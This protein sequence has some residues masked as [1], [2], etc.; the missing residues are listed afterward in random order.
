MAAER[1]REL[2]RRVPAKPGVY[3]FKDKAGCVIY[4]GKAA[5]LKD[6]IR[7]YFA[8][9]A[10][11]AEK[12]RRM[13][14]RAQDF[15]YV[16]T[17]SEQEA[18]ILENNLI[19]KHFP[20]YNVRLRDDKS[21]PY[22]KISVNEDFPRIYVTRRLESD[23][24]R[25][26]G[27]YASAYSV[28]LTL[29]MLRNVFHFRSCRKPIDGKERR[30]CL[31]YHIRR[32]RA[33]CV[34]SITREDYRHTIDQVMLFLE[35]RQEQIVRDL[36]TRMEDAAG[37]LQFEKAALLRDQ[38]LAVESVMQQQKVVSPIPEDEDVVGLA[39]SGDEGCVQLFFVRAGKLT[40]QDHFVMEGAQ[41]EEPRAILTS[42]V[43]QF[44]G[45]ASYV[46]PRILLPEKLEDM[47]VVQAW[48]SSRRGA[49]VELRAPQ[50]GEKKKLVA[51]AAQNAAEMLEQLRA[52][53][54]ADAGK[55]QVAQEELQREL[56]LPR[57]PR[58]IECYDI[59]NIQGASAVGS[60]VVFEDGRPKSKH[61]RRFQIK[62]VEGAD[63]YAM[64]QE[65]LRRRFKHVDNA[66]RPDEPWAITPDLVIIDGGK[67]QLNAA[68]DAM[69]ELGVDSIPTAGLAKEQ[70]ELFLSGR[71]DPVRLPR[72]SQAL[73]LVQRIRDE[74]HRFALAY[75]LKVRTRKTL[76][77]AFDSV[78][79]IGPRRRKA[80]IKRFGSVRGVREATP[81]EL[82][83]VPGITVA[84]ANQIKEHL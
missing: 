32:C 50:R 47:E 33:P 45:A 12:T 9:P 34:G 53:W 4:V 63:D 74:A 75:H 48:L 19:K 58:R 29:E 79:G 78:P 23:G 10:S 69:K 84:L 42:F 83:S 57:P 27:P 26:F 16:L 73:Y 22:L 66:A 65:V 43:E 61:Y 21:Y 2:L 77:S 8:P 17:D 44:Y 5:S 51:L 60:M 46:P 64:L 3:L 41:G 59:S 54:L 38:L 80:L 36:K 1:F 7:S 62:T 37:A 31:E 71:P 56:Q 70:E 39:R 52:K 13:M 49:K 25:Y 72:T 30:P 68:L 6:R 15:D 35:G 55:T 24:G 76:G 67:G 81:E 20:R 11:L 28:R 14:N 18:L 40:G 82:A